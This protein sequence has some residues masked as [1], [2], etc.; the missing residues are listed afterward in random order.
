MKV[1][2]WLWVAAGLL[3][4]PGCGGGPLVPEDIA[5]LLRSEG[6]R[7]ALKAV[8]GHG[9]IWR[10]RQRPYVQFDH[11]V[12]ETVKG[13]DTLV[14]NRGRDTTIT[15]RLDT[16]L[17]VR[18]SCVFD[19]KS[20]KRFARSASQSPLLLSGFN[21]DSLW[22]VTN[23]VPDSASARAL[24]GRQL[25]ETWFYFQLPFLLLD[26]TLRFS[27]EGELPQVDTVITKGKEPGTFDTAR[28]EFTITRLKVEWSGGRAPVE[29][30]TFYLDGRDGRIR[31]TLSPVVRRDGSRSFRLTVWT[32]LTDAIGL[33]VGGRRQSF[34]ANADGQVTGP[35]DQDRRFYNVEFP[36]ELE[37]EPFNWT[38]SLQAPAGSQ[39]STAQ[40]S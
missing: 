39:T 14:E 29:W 28:T 10:W 31:R 26:T 2:R 5:A 3:M 9:G 18:E 32:D 6:G 8:E 12:L 11:G 4:L 19:L 34:P 23:G 37:S 20:R 21:G 33:K 35:A 25:E 16:L 38:P 7:M 13:A 22:S 1:L 24:A 27:H 30:M 40:P 17:N 15:P 36:R